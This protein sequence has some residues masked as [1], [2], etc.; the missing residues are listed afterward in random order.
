MATD[1]CNPR[2]ISFA[3]V[4]PHGKVHPTTQG[5]EEWALRFVQGFPDLKREADQEG[6]AGSVLLFRGW[7]RVAN[8][9]AIQSWDANTPTDAAW[10]S[11]VELVRDCAIR[12]RDLDPYEPIVYVEYMD[13]TSRA[14]VYSVAEFIERFGGRRESESFFERLLSRTAATVTVDRAHIDAIRRDVLGIARAADNVETIADIELVRSGINR[15]RARWDTFAYTL[16]QDLEQRIRQADR[17][18]D[19][20]YNPNP[21]D[22]SDAEHYLNRSLVPMWEFDSELNRYPRIDT[23]LKDVYGNPWK[24][25]EEAFE[26][27]V[28]FYLDRGY[29]A[30]RDD[31]VRQAR[32]YH[33]SRPPQ[34]KA[35][36][37]GTTVAKWNAEAVKWTRRLRDK[38]RKAWATLEGYVDWLN[39]W[40]GGSQPLTVVHPESENVPLAGFRVVFRGFDDS[41]YK[42]RLGAVKAGLDRYRA[43]AAA[44]API[45]LRLTPPIFVEWTFEPTTSSDAAAYYTH[46]RV[47]ITPWAIGDDIDGFVKIMAHEVGHHIA[48]GLPRDAM[49]A[50]SQFLRGDYRDLD[51]REALSVMDRVGARSVID[52]SLQ[53][54]DPILHLQLSTLLHDPAYKFH[55]LMFADGIRRYLDGGANPVVQVPTH[56]ITG[57]AAKNNEEAFCEA[58][59]N[60]VA[61]GPR[62]VLPPV[63]VMLR[64]ILGDGVRIASRV[65]HRHLTANGVSGFHGW[66]MT[67]E[68]MRLDG[69]QFT[70]QKPIPAEDVVEAADYLKEVRPGLLVAY[71]RGGAVAMLA[72]RESGVRPKVIWV[73]P[74][75]RRGWARVEPPSV[76]GVILHGDMDNAVPLQHSCELAERTGLPLRVI[77]GR[78]HVNILNNK[79]NPSAG[80]A[81][82][83]DKVRECAQTLPDWGTSGRGSAD[84]VARQEEFARS[85][86][87][88]EDEL[89][90]TP[91]APA[92]VATA[93]LSRTAWAGGACNLGQVGALYDLLMARTAASRPKYQGK[94]EVPKAD[95][96]GTTMV[97]QYGP[98]QVANRHK[99]KAERVEA[100]RGRIGDLRR[101]F[102]SDLHSD[103]PETRLTALAVAL[104]DATYE[105]VGNDASADN[106]HYGVTGWTMDHV[107]FAK[108]GKRAT[109]RY[110]GKS[111]VDHEKTV[112]D[113]ALVKALKSCCSDKGKD[114]P[115]LSD[116]DVRVTSRMVNDY[117]RE[118]DITAKDLRGFHANREMQERLRA[119]RRDGPD[120]PRPRK[121]RDSILKEEFA[122]ALEGAAEAVGHEASTLRKQYLV[123]WLE[124]SYMKDGTVIDR[125]DKR[126]SGLAGW[127]FT[128]TKTHAEREDE[129]VE[130]LVRRSPKLKPS[131]DDSK[132]ERVD[133][134]DPDI[135]G[136]DLDLSVNYKDNG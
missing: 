112:D 52:E 1:A 94:K 21:P 14:D 110:T 118:F 8:F 65:A 60:L 70:D 128:A 136:R 67:P 16:R 10:R 36:A 59:G 7:I 33:D 50:W 56:P 83:A 34:T 119:I 3:W 27:T 62:A 31:A 17:P 30:T 117:L 93:W 103:D 105:R 53:E 85:L 38:A 6:D 49:V 104:I 61:Y 35:E 81:V 76:N 129:E 5:H 100:L 26:D 91:L 115:V 101:R 77:P 131:R 44:R 46:N 92:R 106:G 82:P 28:R 79:T 48:K 90:N 111:G 99:E 12:T 130:R 124:E 19:P 127:T 132:R 98:R 102:K 134:D 18:Y 96:S 58:L 37:E 80:I 120:L 108:D 25:P 135:Q 113:P 24:P 75:W 2:G 114:D 116:G 72:I 78:N 123:P 54:E 74:A 11:V 43:A 13:V 51:L 40:R 68:A 69:P 66:G 121:E 57:Y 39:S 109:F 133:V 88:F 22:K 32:R 87:A 9:T 73:A 41:P 64:S 23:T 125:L 20:K 4:D 55:D 15:W 97:Y 47:N 71:S 63:L 122:E 29:A 42:D 84:D 126:A 95:G 45:A 89:P 86:T 107:T